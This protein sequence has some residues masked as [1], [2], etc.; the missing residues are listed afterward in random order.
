MQN[1]KLSHTGTAAKNARS[2]TLCRFGNPQNNMAQLTAIIG[3][4]SLAQLP[5]LQVRERRVV[6]TP[7]GETSSPLLFGQIEGASVVFIARHGHGHTIAPHRVNY[8]ANLWALQASG[9]AR[10][11]A[12]SSVGGIAQ[13]LQPRD[14]A[15]PS[16]IIDYTTGRDGTFFEGPDMPVT[17][18][19][20]ADPFD[21][22]LRTVLTRA[23]D[24]AGK[25]A[26]SSGNTYGVTSGPRFE[27]AAEVRRMQQDGC[28]M[29][30]MTAMPEAALARELALEYA[31][32]AVVS[33]RAAGLA[34]EPFSVQSMRETLDAV[35]PSVQMVLSYAARLLQ[36]QE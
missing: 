30:G 15:V 21:A 34:K 14:F 36:A 10:I 20:F 31:L 19:D 5:G 17:H 23:C 12:V 27:T 24:E 26:H 35:L 9:V 6:R 11:L 4:S 18:I 7:Y 22:N 1:A 28:D 3:G 8:R 32:L 13:G 2:A 25:P 16:Q 29:V 33:N